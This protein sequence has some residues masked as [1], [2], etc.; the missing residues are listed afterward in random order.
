MIRRGWIIGLATAGLLVGILVWLPASVIRWALPS[1]STCETLTG[2]LWHGRCVGLS[3]RG[4]RSGAL[5]WSMRGVTIVRPGVDVTLRWSKEQ[6]VVEGVLRLSARGPSSLSLDRGSIEMETLRNS[7]PADMLLGPLAGVAGQL[8]T[9]GLI[10]ELERGQLASIRGELILRNATLLKNGS[11]IGP[12]TARFEGQQGSVNDLGGP[13]G[14]SATLSI[15][16][17]GAFKAKTRIETR[18]A[19]VLPGIRPG[20]PIEADIEG[21]F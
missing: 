7:L 10:L 3:L 18:R 8:H 9:A 16:P 12:F 5:A 6:S 4:S 11:A 21:R 14:L 15:D 2:T 20:T 17:P 19:D 1:S 13:L